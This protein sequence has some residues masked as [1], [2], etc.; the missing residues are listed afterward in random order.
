MEGQALQSLH[1]K[2]N[3]ESNRPLLLC[4]ILLQLLLLV[5]LLIL[6]LLLQVPPL[7]EMTLRML[8]LIYFHFSSDPV[9]NSG[10]KSCKCVTLSYPETSPKG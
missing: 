10:R 7:V 6:L 8:R 5:R 4:V 1:Q 9:S 2:H 3:L